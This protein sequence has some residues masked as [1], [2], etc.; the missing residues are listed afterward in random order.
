[1]A[2]LTITITIN[3][4]DQAILKNRLSDINEWCQKAVTGQINFAWNLMREEWT[5]K[6]M[7]DDSFTDPIP[8][9]KNEFVALVTAR[10]DY[11]TAQQRN[12]EAQS[13]L[14]E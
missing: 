8:S 10:S 1:M 5:T 2:D 14:S 11:K 13:N 4:T 12:E 6:L 3:D 7:D 9:T